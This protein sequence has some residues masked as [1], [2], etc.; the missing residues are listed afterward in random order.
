M[1]EPWFKKVTYNDARYL[2]SVWKGYSITNYFK[3]QQSE[4]DPTDDSHPL[5]RSKRIKLYDVLI[6]KKIY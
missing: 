6:Q 3:L 1:W 2:V 5:G 4:W